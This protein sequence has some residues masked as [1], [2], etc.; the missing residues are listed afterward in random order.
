MGD[1]ISREAVYD[2]IG[3]G[4]RE[5]QM[6][7]RAIDRIPAVDAIPVEW[8]RKRWERWGFPDAL[9]PK[10]EKWL[11]EDWQKEQEASKDG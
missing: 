9:R 4:P 5:C 11:I 7:K 6:C 10:C 3:Y 2:A 1:L 8:I